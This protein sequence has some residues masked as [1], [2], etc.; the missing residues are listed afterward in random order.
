MDTNLN[1]HITRAV[2]QLFAALNTKTGE[3]CDNPITG[4]GFVMGLDRIS[5]QK[6]QAAIAL[7]TREWFA[8]NGP[9]DAPPLPLSHVDVEHYLD[10][11]GLKGVVGLY[12]RSLSRQGYD[13]RK[14]PSFDDFARGL[15][16]IDNWRIEKDETLKKRFPPRPLAG[17]T[18]SGFWATP[19][20][21]EELQRQEAEHR[22]RVARTAV[23]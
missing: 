23:N 18:V 15:M 16:A 19:D 6:K 7:Q 5:I 17:M 3:C 13:I 10:A 4:G 14:H 21:Y 12:A 22:L 2:D 20:E 1:S 8:K 11:R 9:I